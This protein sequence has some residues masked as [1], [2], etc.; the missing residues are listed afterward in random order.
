MAW[1]HYAAGQHAKRDKT[2][3]HKTECLHLSLVI[4][5]R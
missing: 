2:V 1:A 4:L 5:V 3:A